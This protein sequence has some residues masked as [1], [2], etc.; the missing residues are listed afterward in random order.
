MISR[1]YHSLAILSAK[2][3]IPWG[4]CSVEHPNA[5]SP[6]KHTQKTSGMKNLP[7]RRPSPIHKEA[8]GL[9][10]FG[11]KTGEWDRGGAP[12]HALCL[13]MRSKYS[14]CV[15]WVLLAFVVARPRVSRK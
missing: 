10:N 11:K 12:F 13:S 5:H 4:T 2:Y 8:L 6:N 9:R 15:S 7:P 3:Y 14:S 1:T